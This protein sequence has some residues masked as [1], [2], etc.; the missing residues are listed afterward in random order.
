MISQL[1]FA[2]MLGTVIFLFARRIAFVTRNIKMGRNVDLSDRPWER[3]KTMA[4][5]A[6]GQSKMVARPIPGILHILVYAGFVIINLEMIEIV[7]DGLLGT[8]RVFAP[9][10]SLYNILIASFEFL[11]LH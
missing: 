5:V 2:L 11:A 6:I 7:I 9:L 8:H 4:L 10:G 1:I 3:F